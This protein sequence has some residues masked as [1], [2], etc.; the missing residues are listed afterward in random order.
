M[1]TW[2]QLKAGIPKLSHATKWTSYNPAGHLS[3][4][5]FEC[6]EDCINYCNKTGDIPLPPDNIHEVNKVK[7]N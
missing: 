2:H 4:M 7:A 5:R 3:V 6:Y 1:A